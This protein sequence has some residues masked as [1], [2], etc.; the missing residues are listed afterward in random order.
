MSPW[1][2][3]TVPLATLHGKERAIAPVFRELLGVEVVAVPVD[4]DRFGTF[5]GEIPRAGTQL[6]A[7]RQKARAGMG[8]GPLGLASE[9]AFGP[10]PLGLGSWN[11]EILVFLDRARGLEVVGGA[12]G[13]ALH[14]CEQV[15][16][17]AQAEAA[18]RRAG[19]PEHGVVVRHGGAVHKGIRTLDALAA[20]LPSVGPAIVESD[21]RAHQ[22]P[23]RMARIAEAARDL[24]VRLVTPCPRCGSPGFGYR[25]AVPGLP[26][27]VCRTPTEMPRAERHACVRCPHAADHPSLE[28]TADPR[29]CPACNP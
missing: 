10:S 3:Q 29:W 16:G 28:R 5:T 26:C 25:E 17:R 20:A 22:H 19:F 23:G 15:D 2:G 14:V 13:A 27:S 12:S 1:A 21:L 8:R 6:E 7:A 11:V 18:A 4:T 24:A 9:G